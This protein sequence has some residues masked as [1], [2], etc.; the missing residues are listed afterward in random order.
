MVFRTILILLAGP[1]LSGVLTA[2]NFDMAVNGRQL[3]N[4]GGLM[5]FHPGDDP[6]LDWADPDYND[7]SW[8]LIRGNESWYSQGYPQLTGFAWYRFKVTLPQRVGP[9]ALWVPVLDT[10]FE[11]F[12]NGRQIARFGSTPLDARACIGQNLVFPI[13]ADVVQSGRPLT[14]AIRVWFKAS[15]FGGQYGGLQEAMQLGDA[16][17]MSEWQAHRVREIFWAQSQYNANGILFL[18]AGLGSLLLFLLRPTD[19]EFLWFGL[20]EMVNV[21]YVLWIAYCNFHSIDLATLWEGQAVLILVLNV[22]MPTMIQHFGRIGRTRLYWTA[23]AVAFADFGLN[24]A[25]TF[26][27]IGATEYGLVGAVSKL[28]L[29]ASA[30][31]LLFQARKESKSEMRAFAVPVALYFLNLTAVYLADALVNLGVTGARPI[32]NIFFDGITQWPFP[33]GTYQATGIAIQLALFAILLRR[34][35]RTRGDEE[36]YKG[37]MEAA[38]TVQQVLVPDAIPTVAG[39]ALESVYKPAGQVGGDFFQIIP[40]AEGGVLVAIGDVS[41]K[42]MPAAMTVS[43]LVGTLRTLAHYTES[44]SEILWAMNQRMLGRSS[45]GFTTCLILTVSPAGRLTAANAGHIAPYV[46]G[47]ELTLANGLPLGLSEHEK[48][49]E[50]VFTLAAGEQLTL[51]TDGVLEARAASGE[52]LGFERVKALTTQSA[53][54]I[55]R[56]AESFGQDDDITVMTLRL[57]GSGA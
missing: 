30:C 42:G 32:L 17:L 31:G 47:R 7:S 20:F 53:E 40:L 34:F 33:L 48:Y 36:R 52:L 45:G 13:P 29:A 41:G 44:P 18:L 35:V 46:N 1:A 55:M 51:M 22:S 12:A 54:A 2:Q 23:I 11:I 37:E 43:L 10:N 8:P 38:R 6:G 28:L 25:S 26:N 21:F 4:L 9:L 57:A 27:W 19:R 16:S 14:I 39:F 56:A 15:W 50:S 49:S 3:V 5:R 24:M